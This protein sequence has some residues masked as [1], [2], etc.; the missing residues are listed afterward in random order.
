M[1]LHVDCPMKPFLL[2]EED[3]AYQGV[4]KAQSKSYTIL[5]SNKY[6]YTYSSVKTPKNSVV[7]AKKYTSDLYSSDITK[8]QN[9]IKNTYPNATILAQPSILYNCH[10]YAW[11]SASTSNKFWID[12]PSKY[13][14]DG[15]YKYLGTISSSSSSV[16]GAVNGNKAFYKNT[17]DTYNHSAIIYNSTL[18]TSKLGS[19]CL[20]RHAQAYCP[21]WFNTTK[22]KIYARA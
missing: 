14:S 20:I 21:Y 15:S 9:Y 10:S 13:M 16:T 12:D 11:H 6:Y 18:Y 22:I 8:F 19:N 4:I 3:F 2:N 7:T 1:I 5:N 17:D